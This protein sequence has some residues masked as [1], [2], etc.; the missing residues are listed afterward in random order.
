PWDAERVGI[1]ALALSALV[2]GI[3]SAL[4]WTWFVPGCAAVGIFAAGF[5]A[6]RGPLPVL[7]TAGAPAAMVSYR[8]PSARAWLKLPRNPVR[9]GV[10]VAV[11]FAAL[12]CAWAVWQPE[13][14]D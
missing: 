4:D 5:V 12:I 8:P 2:F 13:R 11:I 3:H 10:G 14:S 1:V 7:A 9:V 6:G